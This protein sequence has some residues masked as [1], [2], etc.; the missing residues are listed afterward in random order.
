MATLDLNMST[1][2]EAH[3]SAL[4]TNYDHLSRINFPELE[5]NNVSIII[6]IDLDLIH[7]EQIIK[8]LKN[9]PWGVEITL[10]WTCAGKTNLV[11]SESTPVQYTQVQNC[12]NMIDS[13]FKSVQDWMRVENLGIALP[14]KILSE[15]DERA[16]ENIEFNTKIVDGHYQIG[17]LWKQGAFLSTTD[18]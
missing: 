8:S 18:S 10:E 4:C 11:F 5:R 14:R 13:L 7:Y 3:L 6:G 12:P 9:A 16:I 15:N 1:V 2:N 17:L